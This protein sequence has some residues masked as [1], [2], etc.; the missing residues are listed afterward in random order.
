MLLA[1]IKEKLFNRKNEIEIEELKDS[2]GNSINSEALSKINVNDDGA[3]SV[4]DLE[5]RNEMFVNVTKMINLDTENILFPLEHNAGKILE[6]NDDEDG[7]NAICPSS[8]TLLSSS[9]VLD[10]LNNHVYIIFN[11]IDLTKITEKTLLI[12]TYANC[13]SFL[14]LGQ[15]GIGR[16]AGMLNYN[17]DGSA[18]VGQIRAT[19]SSY[20]SNTQ[21][22]IETDV[23]S[24][25]GVGEYPTA[26][27]FALSI[28]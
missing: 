4:N 22:V 14:M 18:R 11:G 9:K 8:L 5:V 1:K 10:D 13:F 15:T 23:T 16:V 25:F 27:L 28:K 17:S 3:V 6:I 26:Y 12:L 24:Q 21:I 20:L 19:L 2:Q 7:F